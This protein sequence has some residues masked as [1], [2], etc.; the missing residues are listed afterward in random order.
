MVFQEG[1]PP[2]MTP[3]LRRDQTTTKTDPNPMLAQLLPPDPYPEG[4]PN[5]GAQP[6]TEGAQPKSKDHQIASD[7]DRVMKENFEYEQKTIE[8]LFNRYQ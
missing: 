7:I 5:L 1:L 4:G 2:S 3:P 8:T 6:G